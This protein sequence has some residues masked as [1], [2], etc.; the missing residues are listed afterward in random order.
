MYSERMLWWAIF[1]KVF[2]F[3]TISIFFSTTVYATI[4]SSFWEDTAVNGVQKNEDITEKYFITSWYY[5]PLPNQKEYVTGSYEWDIKLNGRWVHGASGTW[6]FAWMLAAPKNYPFGTKIYLEDY[7]V[8]A[9]EDRGGAIVEASEWG[10][11]YD[12]IDIWMG[13]GDEWRLRA[14]N[15]GKKKIKWTIVSKTEKVSIRLKSSI[16]DIY[17]SLTVWPDS[18]KEDVK[19]L[20]L[21][22]QEIG[23]YKWTI[24][25]NYNDIKSVITAYQYEKGLIKNKEDR[26][27]GH[28]WPKTVQKLK[29][30][31]W[32]SL[33]KETFLTKTEKENIIKVKTNIWKNIK[34]KKYKKIEEKKVVSDLIKKLD[35]IKE[36]SKDKK[37]KIKIEYLKSII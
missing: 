23:K 20:Q 28:F 10:Y 14:K 37:F 6:V 4:S 31:L 25:W 5:S 12:R 1:K 24:N 29:E 22:F 8:G 16:E 13:Y 7:W 19:N 9:V 27:A 18:E 11:D 35:S 3:L 17:L 32:V 33:G 30:D 26:W 34:A 2:F 15:W 36:K 21:F